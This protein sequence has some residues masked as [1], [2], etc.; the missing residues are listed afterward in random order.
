MAK[1]QE[2]GTP[3]PEAEKFGVKEAILVVDIEQKEVFAVSKVKEVSGD[4]KIEW[5]KPTQENRAGFYA[6]KSSPL[7]AGY[8]T[9]LIKKTMDRDRAAGIDTKNKPARYAFYKVP[10]EKVEQVADAVKRVLADSK[11]TQ[12]RQIMNPYYTTARNLSNVKHESN[13]IPKEELKTLYGIDLDQHPNALNRLSSDL[14]CSELFNIN[15]PL[16]DRIT[17]KGKVGL[18][19]YKDKNDVSQ[20]EII[21]PSTV[22]D[23]RTEELSGYL[24]RSEIMELNL[25][26]EIGHLVELP[27]RHTGAINACHV[28]YDTKLGRTV[29]VPR[30]EARVPSYYSG[31]F[32]DDDK[33]TK[34]SIG[35]T[36]YVEGMKTKDGTI[37][38]GNVK[39]SPIEGTLVTTNQVYKDP[40][41]FPAIRS[42]LNKQDLDKL[43]SWQAVDGSKLVT[44]KGTKMNCH[45]WI[46]HA[47]NG[48]VFGNL[49]NWVEEHNAYLAREAEK[50]EKQE[51]QSQSVPEESEEMP[52]QRQGRSMGR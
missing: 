21:I 35:E 39:Y 19:F 1:K 47:T 22:R 37:Y 20:V 29:A 28:A 16:S 52:Q 34:L 7:I 30:K 24:S 23:Y 11:D 4:K 51:Q 31:V 45:L 42:Q 26:N 25:K 46:S 14:H 10:F 33:T 49:K 18:E 38:N 2:H 5:V 17:M 8:L 41:I 9:D 27:D 6:V 13:E 43:L 44:S 36:L 15:W 3:I 32:L 40:Y 12:A 50:Q 48:M